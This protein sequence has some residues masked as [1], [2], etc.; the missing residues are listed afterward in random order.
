M[1]RA[2]RPDL[3]AFAQQNPLGARPLN[4]YEWLRTC[5]VKGMENDIALFSRDYKATAL[6]L[7][8]AVSDMVKALD[9]PE[10]N[11]AF[12]RVQRASERLK[13]LRAAND[14]SAASERNSYSLMAS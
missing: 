3:R 14:R 9:T 13:R 8:M 6:G 5:S 11:D 1:R 4:V 7:T 10:F 12:W 2:I